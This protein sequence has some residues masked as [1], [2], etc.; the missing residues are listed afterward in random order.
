[1]INKESTR[2]F[3]DQHEKSICKALGGKQTSNSG[4]NRFEK[5]DI[6]K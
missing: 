4:A 5:G 2:Y 3:S 1:M 6:I